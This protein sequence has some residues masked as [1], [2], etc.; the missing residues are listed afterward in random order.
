MYI[1]VGIPEMLA[2]LSAFSNVSPYTCIVLV[3]TELLT[4]PNDS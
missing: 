1:D 2:A 4:I 3:V